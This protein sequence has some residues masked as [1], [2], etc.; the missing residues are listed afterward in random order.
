MS[1]EYV[2]SVEGHPI[3]AGMAVRY[4]YKMFHGRPPAE[5][6]SIRRVLATDV[7]RQQILCYYS[8]GYSTWRDVGDY[9]LALHD[10]AT[11]ILHEHMTK[12]GPFSTST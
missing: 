4:A 1:S 5:E 7:V 10:P 2:R 6:Q 12:A 3:I 8:D 11:K 9:E